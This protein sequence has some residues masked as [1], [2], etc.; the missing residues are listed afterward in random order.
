MHICY[1]SKKCRFCQ[2]FFEEL[3]ATP[4]TKEIRFICVDPSPG[5]PPLPAWLKSVPALVVNG[6]DT[7]RV[8]PSAVNNWLFE[9]KLLASTANGGASNGGGSSSATSSISNTP[10]YAAPP[11]PQQSN[12]LPDPISANTAASSKQGPPVLAGSQMNGIEAWHGAEMS[13]SA[14]S[15]DYSFLDDAFTSEKGYNPIVRNWESLAGPT[16]GR[17]PGG[18]AAG[19][20]GAGGSAAGAAGGLGSG[21]KSA[22]EEKLIKEFEQFSKMRDMEFSPIKRM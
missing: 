2:A 14:W 7:P 4:Y 8:G 6:E 1:F 16:T 5:R 10:S 18:G 19:A 11:K 22:K 13:G 21:P 15:D 3:S 12:K 9:R 17:G 20:G